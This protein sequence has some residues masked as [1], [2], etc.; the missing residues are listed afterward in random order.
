M[1]EEKIRKTFINEDFL[2]K[3]KLVINIL[4]RHHRKFNETNSFW[5]KF[6]R[7]HGTRVKQVGGRKR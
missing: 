4:E 2:T 1:K 6:A 3:E 5:S 7:K